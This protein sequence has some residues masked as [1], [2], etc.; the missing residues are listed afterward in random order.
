MLKQAVK[1]GMHWINILGLLSLILIGISI[2]SF[3]RRSDPE[4]CVM[5]RMRP[6]Y[7]PLLEFNSTRTIYGRKYGMYLYREVYVDSS[8]VPTGIPIIF[9]PGNRGSYKQ[10]RSIASELARD[11]KQKSEKDKKVLADSNSELLGQPAP[12]DIFSLD[13]NEEFSA[14]H[15]P[16]LSDQASYLNDAIKFLIND[17]YPKYKHHM[18]DQAAPLPRSV[19]LIGHSMGGVV[20]RTVVT[21]K[22]FIPGSV[23]TIITLSS[24]HLRSP[25]PIDEISVRL[26]DRVNKFWRNYPS[27][28]DITLVSVANGNLDKMV[29]SHLADISAISPHSNVI[30]VFSS[31]IP[32]LWTSID[33]DT[34]V[35]CNQV[36][37]LITKTMDQIADNSRPSKTIPLAVRLQKLNLLF[38][39]KKEQTDGPNSQYFDVRLEDKIRYE[40]PM[41]ESITHSKPVIIQLSDF[42]ADSPYKELVLLTDLT[43]DDHN[44]VDVLLCRS[45]IDDSSPAKCLD[46]TS[47]LTSLPVRMIKH[48][49]ITKKLSFLKLSA[50]SGH[51]FILVRHGSLH[52]KK[53]FIEAQLIDNSRSTLV[54]TPSFSN[55]LWGFPLSLEKS[56]LYS[57]IELPLLETTHLMYTLVIPNAKA[58]QSLR[59]PTI[60]KV[61]SGQM[62]EKKYFLGDETL[63]IGF[64]GH[65]KSEI[66]NDRLHLVDRSLDISME[67]FKDK[68]CN[69]GAMQL[70]VDVY[71]SLG[72][73]F[74]RYHSS[75][76]VFPFSIMICVLVIQLKS[77]VLRGEVPD[78]RASLK[79][80][81]TY[82][83][84]IIA[85]ISIIF[86]SYPSVDSLLGQ[87][88]GLI[89]S[90]DYLELE[91]NW[92]VLPT[93][94]FL[95]IGLCNLY[96]LIYRYILRTFVSAYN[97][98]H[99]NSKAAHYFVEEPGYRRQLIVLAISVGIY[100]YVP[101]NFG[102][103]VAF[104]AHF[105][106]VVKLNTGKSKEIFGNVLYI[107][108]F[109]ETIS[110]ILFIFLPLEVFKI[111]VWI[112]NLSV[113]W[114]GG[115][116]HSVH[117][118]LI[119]IN[120][121]LWFSSSLPRRPMYSRNYVVAFSVCKWTG[122]LVTL[123]SGINH[124]YRLKY[125]ANYTIA[126]LLVLYVSLLFNG[127][128]VGRRISK[129]LNFTL[130][131]F[132]PCVNSSNKDT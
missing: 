97:F 60:V 16:S 53:F 22:S 122:V 106:S 108:R 63:S 83:F 127:G 120:F 46:K 125:I 6:K 130:P 113:H 68:N 61:K 100:T 114:N 54:L 115:I 38:L 104:L 117:S 119:L 71:G 124:I 105:F 13:F 112:K 41:S 69:L 24:P 59:I 19:I 109:H 51:D 8:A 4:Q 5:T 14:L 21:L 65:L 2:D 123:M 7:L 31:S 40:I 70:K 12:F 35:W 48:D 99:R 39:G 93:L 128:K 74:A 77:W 84:P 94:W 32:D 42:Q 37:K 1:A 78:Y 56:Y 55:L 58:C 47:I 10:V 33:H 126:L 116:D 9:L 20:A 87:I 52:K 34:V 49:R 118:F 43:L 64:F 72:K 18:Y 30:S 50:Q 79:Y 132:K 44:T 28:T 96:F 102:Y 95:G 25:A 57:R 11:F 111:L 129:R 86:Y 90:V 73:I 75:T 131:F 107:S 81:L 85:I 45:G 88:N 82:E 26:Y 29:Q 91:N 36:V 110:L 66:S 98:I 67:F 101:S 27:D 121:A 76:V 17:L 15:G 3:K 23:N 80:H 92:I 62:N 103:L 89:G